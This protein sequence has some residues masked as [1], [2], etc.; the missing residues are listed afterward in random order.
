MNTSGS[1][2]YELEPERGRVICPD[3]REIIVSPLRMR[4]LATLH[5]HKGNPVSVKKLIM[6]VWGGYA[7]DAAVHV[8]VANTR[9]QI[10]PNI[11]DTCRGW[12]Y[13]VGL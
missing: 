4:L 9:R 11:I 8:L 6:Q 1:A 12:G 10:S 2:A 5:Q 3:G 13:G 7:D